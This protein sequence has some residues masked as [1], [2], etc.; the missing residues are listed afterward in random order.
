MA[1]KA[2]VVVV[3][4][5]MAGAR[6]VEALLNKA[7]GRYT[8][9]VFGE[10]PYGNYNR[11]L[12]SSV[13][14]GLKEPAEIFLNPT[15]WYEKHGV[16]L[17]LGVRVVKVDRERKVA[18]GQPSRRGGE[19]DGRS[20]TLEEPYDYLVLATGSRPFVPPIPGRELPGV[21]VFRTL[22][23]CLA[24][25]EA[26]EEA[27]RAVVIGGGLLGLEAA[28]GLHGRGV[29]VSVVE[30]APHLMV[31]QLDPL[32]G[33]I[34]QRQLEKL[35]LTIYVQTQVSRILGDSHVEA[36]ELHDGRRIEAD[37]V[38]ISC[39]IRPNV[40]LAREAGLMVQRGIV[41]D[42]Q[43]RTSDPAIFALGE[44]AEHRGVTYGIVEPVYEQAEILA[45]ILSGARPQA[46]YEGSRL[47]TTLKVIGVD[48]TSLGEV[49]ECDGEAQV[50]VEADMQAGRYRKLIVKE[51]RV[52]G[53]ILLGE[54]ESA[55][56]LLLYYRTGEKLPGHPLEVWYQL[57]KN[58]PGQADSGDHVM[59]AASLPED[60]Q[61][62]N[63]HRV[64]KR[65]I[66]RCIRAGATS[67]EAIGQ[68]CKAGTGCGSCQGLLG[69]L[70]AHY[71]RHAV[72]QAG[73]LAD[74]S[75]NKIELM[76]QEKDGLDS[77]PD[78]YRYAQSGNWEE[79]TED[80][81]QR[82]KWHGLFFRKPTPGYF[83]LRIR[84]TCGQ[85]NA[86]QFRVIAELSDRFG[87]GFC[88][89]TTRQQ[90]QMRWF[91]IR[92]VPE[93]WARLAE[94]GLNSKQTGMDNVRGVCGCPLSGLAA[95]ELFDASPVAHEF[96]S[97]ILDNREFTNLPRKFN[98]TITGCLENCCHTETQDIA[99]VPSYREL[100]GAQ[101]FGFNVLVGGKQGSGG[102]TPAKPLDVFVSQT[103]AARLCAEIVRIFRDHGS[104]ES[105]TR[106][107]LA[108]LIQDRG[109]R[110]FR[111][112]LEKRWGRPL[113]PAGP[114]LRKKHHTDHLGIQ[115]QKKRP[116]DFGPQ[117]FS[118][119]L[120]V[121]VGRITT[122]QMR[123]VAD[124]AERYG[125]GQ[126]RLT[127]QQNIIIPNVPEDRLSALTDEPLL[128]ELPI[129]PS[130]ILRGLVC[131]TGND[132]CHFAL[133][134]T[135]GWALRVA[136]ELERRTQGQNIA[137]LTIH[138]SGCPAGCG[139]HQVATIGLQ[140]CR[141]RVGDA[142]VD[143][144]H[145]YVNGKSGPNPQVATDVMYDVPCDKL[146]DALEPLVR[147]LPRS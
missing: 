73:A 57:S 78:I 109:I 60:Q 2:T 125:N 62:C 36:V 146:A 88:D 114:E 139:L 80:D 30:I 11:I 118:V 45:E 98:V 124:L 136:R 50:F 52:H 130:P 115:P 77:L 97:I 131:C 144:A 70:L 137:P 104:R 54:K 110:W 3:G 69:H 13:V 8:V 105:R 76:K 141:T 51:G 7:P 38:I 134:D 74:T 85:S 5:G 64:P 17:H 103:E 40:E 120:L 31:Q 59:S 25:L 108:F 34:L 65:E 72:Q 142:V 27:A 56:K 145:V 15:E 138:M 20:F 83:M 23:D 71:A 140:A 44:C 53:A 116:G 128:K 147:F 91:S 37:L 90:I 33:R 47:A 63:C 9:T 58:G 10:E 28:R 49:K 99:L 95:H 101:V 24:I 121:P 21:F 127:V 66:V 122:D 41:V 42:D 86:R 81:K 82:F 129:N 135:K 12:L 119:G 117:L 123:G 84:H 93:I 46:R 126:I 111:Q 67:I 48:L 132:Y 6:F 112:E 55:Q 1:G 16:R 143:A 113:H 32:G 14:A 43:L 107:R 75:Q 102:Y 61:I 18:V 68:A 87:K 39:G 96:T 94:V 4:N 35:G 106:A 26:A 79:M 29:Q 92:D 22:D 19:A 133:I 89:L 100:E